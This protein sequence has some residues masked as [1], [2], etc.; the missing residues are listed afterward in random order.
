MMKRLI[1]IA[2]VTALVGCSSSTSIRISDP[3]A[4]IFVNG[5]YVGTGHGSYQD[6]KPAFTEQQV[7]LRKQGCADESYSFRRNERPDLGAI[8]SAYYLV[9][10]ILWFTQYENEHEYEFE[11]ERMASNQLLTRLNAQYGAPVLGRQHIK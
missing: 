9:L 7:R 8:I 10:P 6:H 5:E 11:C 4:R 1:A 3:E 2:A